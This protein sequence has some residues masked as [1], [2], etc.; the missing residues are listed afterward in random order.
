M[1][2]REDRREREKINKWAAMLNSSKDKIVKLMKKK[3][4]AV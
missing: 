1:K 2:R 4:M 3:K